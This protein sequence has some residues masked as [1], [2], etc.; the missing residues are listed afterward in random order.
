MKFLVV[1][2]HALI[3]EAMGSV[4]QVARPGCRVLEASDGAAA[5]ATL[6]HDDIDFALLDLHS[7]DQ[8][9]LSLLATLI[10]SSLSS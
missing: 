4:L 9:G 1:D 5:L 6:D 8:G 2:D 3:R 7:P 10:P